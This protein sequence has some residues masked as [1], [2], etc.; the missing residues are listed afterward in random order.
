MKRCLIGAL[1]GVLGTLAIQWGIR[2]AGPT[3]QQQVSDLY[4]WAYQHVPSI[5]EPRGRAHMLTAEWQTV[6]T[7]AAEREGGQTM[8]RGKLVYEVPA[9]VRVI[10]AICLLKGGMVISPSDEELRRLDAAAATLPLPVEPVS[11]SR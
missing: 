6:A 1:V 5:V 2:H 8:W 3:Q 10:K 11:P 9:G 4:R 7:T